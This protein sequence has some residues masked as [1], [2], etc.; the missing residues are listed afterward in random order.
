[1]HPESP[2]AS[3]KTRKSLT[4]IFLPVVLWRERTVPWFGLNCVARRPF[5]SENYRQPEVGNL[6]RTILGFL[7]KTTIISC[8]HRT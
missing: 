7:P 6:S 8:A 5:V 3:P 4:M 1:M 2:T